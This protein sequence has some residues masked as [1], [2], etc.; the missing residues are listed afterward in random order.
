VSLFIGPIRSI[1][2]WPAGSGG[3]GVPT[4]VAC[5]GHKLDVALQVVHSLDVRDPSYAATPASAGT[6]VL[7]RSLLLL[8]ASTAFA[9]GCASTR[10]LMPTPNLYA[11]GAEP[12]FA[13]LPASLQ[14]P[15]A[16]LVYVTDRTPMTDEGTLQYDA[17]RS[18]SAAWGIARVAIGKQLDWEILER[19]SRNRHRSQ[20]LPLAIE[21]L[22][23][24]G[25]FPA[26][27]YPRIEHR[28][29]LRPDPAI[30]AE[31]VREGERFQSELLARMDAA[32]RRELVIF[33]HG[34]NNSFLQAAFTL[35]ELW[36]FLGRKPVP[37]LYSWPAGYGGPT[38]YAHDRESGEFTIHHLKNLLRVLIA[39]PEIERLNI[40]A[41]SRGADVATSA[42][43]ELFIETRAAGRDARREFR[44]TNQ[45]L[46]AADL[47]VEVMAQ[48]LIAEEVASAI[49]RITV[50]TNSEDKALR[51]SEGLFGSSFRLGKVS[52]ENLPPDAFAHL[53]S[54]SNIDFVEM[55]GRASFLGHGYFH[56]HPGASSDLVLVLRYDRDPGAENGRPL[57][58][59]GPG[60]W[61]LEDDYPLTAPE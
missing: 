46:A 23:E 34:Y 21:S 1:R 59:V 60:F 47:D 52:S 42:L 4:R 54:Q 50:Y 16:E 9:I 57:E 55:R 33:V 29:T 20:P 14:E 6:R 28:G 15:V 35:A 30:V 38:G 36:H 27:P 26:T 37:L 48:R 8:I 53:E 49:G 18:P 10:S 13:D 7:A 61:A 43:R 24:R 12:P 39:T 3:H 25:R 5:S 22:E 11:S 45:V 19:E 40:V 56:S 51:A 41:H 32:G 17:V 31:A 58:P 44:I 2:F